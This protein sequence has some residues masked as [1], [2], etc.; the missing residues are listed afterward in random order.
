M[1]TIKYTLIILILT[2][3]S[4][5][6]NR[7]KIEYTIVSGKFA[8]AKGGELI[9][10]SPSGFKKTTSVKVDGTFVD[11][12]NIEDGYYDISYGKTGTGIYLSKGTLVS[13]TA[14]EKD[15]IGTL[16]FAGDY[17]NL[18][19]Y[20][21]E[22]SRIDY[23]F[24]TRVKEYCEKGETEFITLILTDRK[25]LE[26][27]FDSVPNVPLEIKEKEK[28]HLVYNYLEKK[29]MYQAFY[30][31]KFTENEDY[32]ASEDFMK[33]LKEIPVDRPEDYNY[34]SA[35]N[36]LINVLIVE[37]KAYEEYEKN[38]S[39]D[40]LYAFKNS[41]LQIENVTLRDLV[42]FDNLRMM[43][44]TAKDKKEVYDN[45]INVVSNDELKHK[46]TE[47]YDFMFRLEPGKPS[48]KFVNYENYSG[49][50][51]SLDDLKGKYV[52]IDVWATWCKPC[53]YEMPFL[54][55][56]EK[57]YQGKNIAF[58]SISIDYNKDY[59]NWKKMVNEKQMSGIQL[60]ADKAFSSDFIKAYKINGIP[61]LIL[62]DPQGN[63]VTSNAPKPS[64]KEL[65]DLFNGL[66]I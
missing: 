59:N 26:E 13:F 29:Y 57:K 1:K 14:D 2:I 48:P 25:I 19:N 9:I 64:D 54:Q 36:Y 41:V 17:S 34:S 53:I 27:K 6:E 66:N 11:T 40:F 12:L 8:N 30:H 16:K 22:R 55:E 5:K 52:Y 20:Y 15:F 46:I 33:E 38:P 63:I 60:F 58:V 37:P 62:I 32:V 47:L 65:I 43:L 51:T 21:A 49:G 28:R 42:I 44:P 4:C 45:F 7:P 61:K 23:K 31:A 24:R 35:Y 3:W 50:T 56:I 18:N 10:Q 39:K